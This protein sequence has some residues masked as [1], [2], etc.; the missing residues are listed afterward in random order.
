MSSNTVYLITGANRGL[1]LALVAHYLSAPSN[2]VIAAVRDAS[3]AS[4]ELTSLPVD[5]S[6][7]RIIV[8]IDSLKETDPATA[9]K[10]LSSEHSITHLDVVVAS[11][12]I[13]A[14]F[15]PIASASIAKID[16]HMRVNAYAPL[17]LFQATLPLLEKS[18][19]PKFVGMGSPIASL[20]MLERSNFPMVGYAMS[21][22]VV[23]WLVRKIHLEHEGICAFVLEPGF[24]QTDMGNGVG[25]F[26]GMEGAVV[27]VPDSVSFITT[28]ID[29]ATKEK[30]SGHWPSIEG[31]DFAW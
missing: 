30:T 18:K 6:S 4:K 23:N 2:T 20:S 14:D 27:T 8:S 11:A 28:T 3:S 31:G 12:G 15:S 25:K 9:I 21:K 19:S 1:G 17:L 16:E 26:F 22:I 10:T 5:S 7:K 29:G 13:N 24:V